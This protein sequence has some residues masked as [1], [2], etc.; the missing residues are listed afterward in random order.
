[1]IM[2]VISVSDHLNEDEDEDDGGGDCG[3]ERGECDDGDDV[4]VTIR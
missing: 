1:M 3:G 4:I 2:M